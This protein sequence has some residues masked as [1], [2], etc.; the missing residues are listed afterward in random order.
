MVSGAGSTATH[1]NNWW[2]NGA[3]GYYKNDE[4]QYV[5]NNYNVGG[6]ERSCSGTC[7]PL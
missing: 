3:T 1:I 4:Y 7:D 6:G 2:A 5:S